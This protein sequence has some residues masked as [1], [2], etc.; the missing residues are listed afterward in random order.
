MDFAPS[1]DVSWDA[2]AAPT[3]KPA[4]VQVQPAIQKPKLDAFGVDEAFANFQPNFSTEVEQQKLI[5]PDPV[6]PINDISNTAAAQIFSDFCKNKFGFT[7]VFN[8]K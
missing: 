1:F 4:P 5:Q 6:P 8:Q 7:P 2:P 3:P